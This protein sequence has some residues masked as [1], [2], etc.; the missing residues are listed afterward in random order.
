MHS[1]NPN[2]NSKYQIMYISSS[3][4]LQGGAELCLYK[5]ADRFKEN[6]LVI[7]PK[8]HGIAYE[9]EKAGIKT[10]YIPMKGL[11]RSGG[12]K[13]QAEYLL[14]GFF[15]LF[16]IARLMRKHNI[17]LLHVNELVD[18]HTLFAARLVG[19]PSICHAR[20]IIEKPVVLKN[21]LTYSARKFSDHIICVSNAVREKMFSSD[22]LD[23]PPISVVYD[24]GPD[25]SFFQNATPPR[26]TIKSNLG[27]KDDDVVVGLLSKF[28]EVKGHK[29]LVEAG[30][31]LKEL[32]KNNIRFLFIGG[33][34]K[35]HE[36]YHNDIMSLVDDNALQNQFV[37]AGYRS[38]VPAILSTCDIV[39][40]LPINEDPFP[41]VVLEAMA[42]EK[43]VIAY[44]SGGVPEQI[45]DGHSGFL[46]KKD[47][48]DHL[49]NLLIKLSEDPTLRIDL[50]KNARKHIQKKFSLERHFNEI[51]EI[52]DSLQ[53]PF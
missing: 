22:P 33:P 43:P 1:S 6:A 51:A 31:R 35:G 48:I 4:S 3:T 38:D 14:Q 20:F 30:R 46:I 25:I 27:F 53:T 7:L 28:V 13:Y 24:G 19:I 42:M 8:R 15:S 44:Q 21:F 41:G 5:L 39:V 11:S 2:V 18:L 47:D 26:K 23:N 45:E 9:Y 10:C 40:H 50:G 37:F 32:G 34:V 52:Y 16:Q 12:L 49:I 17:T 36:Q 29:H